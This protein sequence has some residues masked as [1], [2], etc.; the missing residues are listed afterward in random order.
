MIDMSASS[1]LAI[2]DHCDRRELWPDRDTARAWLAGHEQHAHPGTYTA[3]WAQATA[4]RRASE[5]FVECPRSSV[6]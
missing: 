3:R 6:P 4:T 1:A 2:C 5:L